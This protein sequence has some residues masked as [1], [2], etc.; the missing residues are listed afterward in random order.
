MGAWGRTHEQRDVWTYR[1]MDG[2]CK[3]QLHKYNFLKTEKF[4]CI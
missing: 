1:W 2:K 3:Q 4:K